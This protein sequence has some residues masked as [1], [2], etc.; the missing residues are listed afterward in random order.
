MITTKGKFFWDYLFSS[1]NIY[2][3]VLK[4]K[5]SNLKDINVV[6]INI[7]DLYNTDLI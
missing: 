4:L 7:E 1:P 3:V 2:K 6:D 5:H